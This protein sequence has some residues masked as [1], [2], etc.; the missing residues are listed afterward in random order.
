MTALLPLLSQRSCMKVQLLSNFIL[1]QKS[2]F[3]NRVSIKGKTIK[4][5]INDESFLLSLISS[6]LTCSLWDDMSDIVA[7]TEQ[8]FHDVPGEEQRRET[9]PDCRIFYS[10]LK[11]ILHLMLSIYQPNHSKEVP[12]CAQIKCIVL[13]LTIPR[14][15]I[16]TFQETNV[17]V[18]PM[19]I[20]YTYVSIKYFKFALEKF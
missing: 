7:R 11:P 20:I 2:E 12:H 13:L 10:Y 4:T 9:P 8:Y 17:N 16:M 1:R 5:N 14:V 3:L 6:C 15:S 19:A 18:S